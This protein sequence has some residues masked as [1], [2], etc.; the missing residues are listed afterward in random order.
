VYHILLVA[1]PISRLHFS[2]VDITG[3]SRFRNSRVGGNQI[4]QN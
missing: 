3:T 1:V 2:A 4:K